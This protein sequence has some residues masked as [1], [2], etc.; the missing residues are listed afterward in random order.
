MW[1]RRRLAEGLV[2]SAK[3]PASATKYLAHPPTRLDDEAT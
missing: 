3:E 2:A 1:S